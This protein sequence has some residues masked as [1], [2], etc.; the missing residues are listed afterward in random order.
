ME[1][2]TKMHVAPKH[3]EGRDHC[4]RQPTNLRALPWHPTAVPSFQSI[5][6]CSTRGH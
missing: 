6:A 3:R 2:K 4:H 1:I 5:P